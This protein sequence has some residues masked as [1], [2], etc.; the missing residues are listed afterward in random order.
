MVGRVILRAS[1]QSAFPPIEQVLLGAD[2]QQLPGSLI[3]GRLISIAS[4]ATD[5]IEIGELKKQMKEG[6]SNIL[7]AVR[8]R[9]LSNNE[10]L[11]SS[12]ETVTVTDSKVINLNDP[13]FEMSPNDVASDESRCCARTTT[14]ASS[15][16]LTLFS[17]GM[18]AR[19]W[20]SPTRPSFW[21]MAYSK[22][23]TLRSLPTE[24]QEP[25]R[26]LR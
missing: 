21:S 11:I 1:D 8:I 16:D 22:V 24:L 6:K 2:H 5:N 3:A 10:L 26:H 25:A 19:A 20:F 4:M 14:G 13:Q 23:T 12:H 7:V 18:P 17:I 15:M 9:P